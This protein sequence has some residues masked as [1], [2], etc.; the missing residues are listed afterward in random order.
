MQLLSTAFS[1]FVS[2]YARAS[3]D[4]FMCCSD[5]LVWVSTYVGAGIR[6]SPTSRH[7]A[8]VLAAG[9]GPQLHKNESPL[10]ALVEP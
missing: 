8:K 1:L 7:L 2:T 5:V 9:H 3:P 10:P 6:H 4:T